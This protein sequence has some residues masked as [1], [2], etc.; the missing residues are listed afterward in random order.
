MLL[1]NAGELTLSHVCDA[2]E[3]VLHV[4]SM[5]LCTSVHLFQEHWD[6]HLGF[7]LSLPSAFCDVQHTPCAT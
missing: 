5:S 6:E 7:A 2:P 1:D 3:S 4:A